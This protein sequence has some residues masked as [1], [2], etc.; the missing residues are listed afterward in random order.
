VQTSYKS[1]KNGLWIGF[2]CFFLTC[3]CSKNHHSASQYSIQED[4]D[5]KGVIEKVFLK[6]TSQK[7]LSELT[8]CS[9][10]ECHFGGVMPAWRVE[11]GDLDGDGLAELAFGLYSYEER[12]KNISNRL[13]IYRWRDGEL[14]DVWRGTA[15]GW[16]FLDFTIIDRNE[17]GIS[18]ILSL[19]IAPQNMGQYCR[20]VIYSWHGFGLIGKETIPVSCQEWL[21]RKG[22]VRDGDGNPLYPERPIIQPPDV[23]SAKKEIE[24]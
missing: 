7:L 2:I 9:G 11:A 5:G 10:D 20:M 18:E 13:Y 23:S 19:E 22:W 8:I 21:A 24:R 4:L 1:L 6:T 3:Y 17:D 15:L 16:P 12:D 14:I